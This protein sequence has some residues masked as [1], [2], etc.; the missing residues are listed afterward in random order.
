MNTSVSATFSFGSLEAM[1]DSIE[2]VDGLAVNLRYQRRTALS[3]VLEK[4]SL[5]ERRRLV[6]EGL[7]HFI[8]HE[9]E[10]KR[11]DLSLLLEKLRA[12]RTCIT[13]GGSPVA[14]Q[15]K[16]PKLSTSNVAAITHDLIEGVDVENIGVH[17]HQQLHSHFRSV[18]HILLA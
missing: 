9:H 13:R 5:E 17:Q 14:A 10:R 2:P 15:G 18:L 3:A 16:S 11:G 12:I 4:T 7:R 8:D 1:L 6:C